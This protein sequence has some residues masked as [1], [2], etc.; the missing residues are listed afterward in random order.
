MDWKNIN[1]HS[2]KHAP[3]RAPRQVTHQASMPKGHKNAVFT[4]SIVIHKLTKD[5]EL[6]N[7]NY[8]QAQLQHV[9]NV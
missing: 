8:L 1:K 5:Q 6:E 2:A 4:V 7:W 9:Y 3:T